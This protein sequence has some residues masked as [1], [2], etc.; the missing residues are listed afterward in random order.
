MLTIYRMAPSAMVLLALAWAPVGQAQE[1]KTPSGTIE[2]DEV[3]LAYIV[4][5]NIGGGKLHYQGQ[6]YDFKIGGI[7]IGGIGAAELVIDMEN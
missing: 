4:Q 2:I 7:G 5:G 1:A 3:E 6:T